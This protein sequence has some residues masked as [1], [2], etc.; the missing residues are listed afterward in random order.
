MVTGAAKRLGRAASLALAD[1]G[2][3]VAVH[4]NTSGDEAALLAKTLHERGLQSWTFKADLSKPGETQRL[5]SQVIETAG[6]IDYLVNNASIFSKDTL[7]DLSPEA[8]AESVNV[9]ALAPFLLARSFAAQGGGGCIVNYLDARVAGLDKEHIS[10][11]LSKR[12]LLTLTRLMALE[13]APEIR[14]NAVAPGLILPP[15]GEDDAYLERRTT[16]NPLHRSG[17]PEEVAEA[18]LFLLNADFTTG[19]VIYIDGGRHMKENL[20]G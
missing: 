4:Y 3:N 15:T 1:Q 6:P 18:L 20:Y 17:T 13:F 7:E 8:L 9:N 16:T 12:M 14:V 5:V 11:H 10:Y 2:V 19:Q